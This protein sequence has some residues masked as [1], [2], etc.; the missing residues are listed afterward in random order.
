MPFLEVENLS[1]AYSGGTDFSTD[2]V[3]NVSCSFEKGEIVGII[4][5]TG[6][7]KST[8][9]QCLNG[10]IKPT[11]GR[12]LLNGA[13]IWE[14]PKS[15]RDVR[16]KVGLV[17][18]YPEYQLFEETVYKDI[19][20]GPTNMK[21]PASE[22]D[23]RVLKSAQIVR[24]ES[25]LLQKSPFDLS[26]GEKRRCAIAGVISMQPECLILDE[27]TA[28]LDPRG[29]DT[30]LEMVLKYKEKS[31]AA[32]IIVSHSME[33]MAKICDKILVLNQ[34]S[35]HCFGTVNDVFASGSN[36]SKIGLDVPAVTQIALKLRGNGIK[37]SENL[38]TVDDMVEELLKLK[39]GG[40]P[41]E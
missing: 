32:I 41:N 35:V 37:V 17:F 40:G 6:S 2:A 15:I 36:L 34:G 3:N 33:D 1:Y 21:L 5:H 7:G 25:D 24:L 8:L 12:V 22:I 28:G 4:G 19:A 29:R 10:L 31:G 13:D 27:P 14:K 11:S 16:F 39:K 9:V 20:F 18:Q 26:G 23:E 38:F 30:V